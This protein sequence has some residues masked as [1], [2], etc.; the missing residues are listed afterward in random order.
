MNKHPMLLIAW[1]E[2][3]I[4]VANKHPRAGNGVADGRKVIPKA[5]MH[6]EVGTRIHASTKSDSI[7]SVY[8][9]RNVMLVVFNYSRSN[10]GSSLCQ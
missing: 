9:E 6:G 10:V 2:G 3:F 5:C 8:S 4:K 1:K 7:A